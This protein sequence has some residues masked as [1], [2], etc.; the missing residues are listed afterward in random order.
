MKRLILLRHGLT[1]WNENGR[2]MGRSD[3]E[4]NRRGWEQAERARDALA[5]REIDAVYS[6]PQVRTRQTAEPLARTLGKEI[7]VDPGFDEVWLSREWIG[8]TVDELRGNDD[9]ES[10]IA[11]PMHRCD[12]IEPISEVQERTVAAVERLRAGNSGGSVVVVSHG[13]P[14]RAIIAHYL[15]LELAGFRRLAC[16]N[17]SVTEFAFA[18]RGPRLELLNW[19]P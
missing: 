17:G 11:D 19:I 15:G 5:S 13:D 4:L 2:L 10:M 7:V 18:R 8:K 9:L 1:D 12:V 6:S 16:D 3:V 14:L